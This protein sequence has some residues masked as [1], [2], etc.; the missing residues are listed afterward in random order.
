M[1]NPTE[2]A[3]G[4]YGIGQ[5]V[6]RTEDPV[7]L[8][9]EGRYTDDLNEPGQAYA[10][11]VRSPHAHGLLKNI[12]AVKA[13][14]MPGVL[15]VYTAEDLK[16]YGPHKCALD[17]KNRD[18]SPM[19]RPVRKSLAT[20]KVRFAGDPVA[21]VVAE[22]ALQAKDAAEAV[23]LEIEPLAAV[24]RASEAAKPGA[25]QLYDDVPGNVIL[26]F[27]FGEPE[28]VQQAFKE[29]AHIARLSL[30]NTRVVVAAMEPRAGICSFESA[31][32]RWTL[33]A[34]GQGVFGMRNQLADILGVPQDKVRMRT[35][36]V[37][38]SFGMKGSIYPEY[39]CLAHAA[40]ALGRP[41]KWTDERSGS[42]VSD[43]HGRDHEM[44]ASL[45]LS[46]EG[47]FLGLKV[48]G[49]GNVG[50]YVGT[51]APQPPTMN[52]VRNVTSVYRMPALEVSTKAMVTNTSPVSAYRGAG[53]PEANYYM[54]RLI[55]QAAA[56]MGIDRFEL[57][58]RNHV[59]PEQI[60]YKAASAMTYDSGDFGAVFEKALQAADIP[61]FSQRRKQSQGKGK[62]RGL[63]LGSYLEVTAPPNKEMGGIRFEGDGDVTM[64]S[65]TLDY[66]QG[67]AAPFAQVL[68]TRLGIP[69]E[70]IRLLQ[71][72]SD[73]LVFGAGTGGSRTAMMGGGALAE[74]SDLVIKKGKALAGDV[75]E[76][77]ESD[78]EFR[79][80]RF[81]VTGTDRSI[82]LEELAKRFPGKLDV[83]HVTEVIPSAF[84]NGCHVAEVEIDPDT[85]AVEVV[86]Y[87]SVNDFGTVLNPLLVEGQIHGGVVQGIGQC[88]ME[89]AQYDSEAQ[90]LTG[91][92]MDYALPRAGDTPER[93]GWQ[94][95]PVPATTNPLGAKGCGEAG[96]AGAMTSVMNAVLD[97]LR[98]VGISHFDMPASPQRVWQ[99]IQR[100]RRES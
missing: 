87:N 20:G 41:V 27:L 89:S 25:P 45:A 55:D 11:I 5:P 91:S 44:T 69:F 40:R 80:G 4:R 9:G 6:R 66:G 1:E 62:L 81:A 98:G 8:R 7:L 18:G 14:G 71:S 19:K 52:V 49:H 88:L 23:E 57:R 39:V 38:G 75:L 56:A 13:K 72:D 37:G 79:D 17:F 64:I 26:D 28:K 36:H 12:D 60:P 46:A 22:T 61:G 51:V 58:R 43:Q 15:A 30:R 68:S 50:A 32:G 53:R 3:A 90:L 86:R 34:P 76:T 29:A 10:W 33:I 99:A 42:F 93:I 54:E 94:S 35:W 82:S 21:C 2:P 95:H 16:A 92:F 65:G 70:K 73:E 78:I 31:T 84:P 77:A 59:R 24:A 48:E 74:A 85:G 47:K 97:A 83:K 100:A 96:C 63:G 67:H